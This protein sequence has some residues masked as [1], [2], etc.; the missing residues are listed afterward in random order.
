MVQQAIPAEEAKVGAEEGLQGESYPQSFLP[1]K[2]VGAFLNFDVLF[3][4][5]NTYNTTL[6]VY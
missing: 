6:R 2:K 1:V 3:N 4:E 5:F